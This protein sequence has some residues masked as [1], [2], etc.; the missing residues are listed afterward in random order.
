M[1]IENR[2]YGITAS[3]Q[4]NTTDLLVPVEE[5]IL[6]SVLQTQEIIN[7]PAGREFSDIGVHGDLTVD[8]FTHRHMGPYNNP[9][10]RKRSIRDELAERET[11]VPL[12]AHILER[13]SEY[14][15]APAQSK[16]LDNPEYCEESDH[17]DHDSE[18]NIDLTVYDRSRGDI[19]TFKDIM[20]DVR[21]NKPEIYNRLSRNEKTLIKKCSQ[22]EEKV[23]DIDQSQKNVNFVNQ[24]LLDSTENNR[25]G[26]KDTSAAITALESK[27]DSQYKDLAA[28]IAGQETRVSKQNDNL[29]S[30]SNQI[31]SH[32]RT[33]N[34]IREDKNGMA[35]EL[36]EVQ[37]LQGTLQTRII[38]LKRTATAIEDQNR[39]L[40]VKLAH[41]SKLQGSYH[42]DQNNQSASSSKPSCSW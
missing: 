41:L 3:T 17:S 12:S 33:I 15:E 34:K 25:K 42:S 38:E 30:L 16:G 6:N 11:P 10:L 22:L 28:K 7:T 23:L 27:V 14:M 2:Y 20:E 18:S 31:S 40:T 32:S 39:I 9:K 5:Q 36:G 1:K 35:L 4:G 26:L 19:P 8:K 29:I 24:S 37:N 13:D 21:K